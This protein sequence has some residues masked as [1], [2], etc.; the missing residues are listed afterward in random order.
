MYPMDFMF[1]LFGKYGLWSTFFLIFFTIGCA[2]YDLEW[3]SAESSRINIYRNKFTAN[4]FS[5][6]IAIVGNEQKLYIPFLYLK[7]TVSTPYIIEIAFT[8]EK[9]LFDSVTIHSASLI[10][11]NTEK[12]EFLKN[13]DLRPPSEK[14]WSKFSDTSEKVFELFTS[15]PEQLDIDFYKNKKIHVDVDFSIISGETDKRFKIVAPFFAH[16]EEGYT[17]IKWAYTN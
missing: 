15:S 8:S 17:S 14:T 6:N 5:I 2:Q 7:R 12:I 9:I 16:K 11:E 1:K 3:Y 4:N 10:L 13:I